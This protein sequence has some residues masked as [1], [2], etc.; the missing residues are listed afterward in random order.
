MNKRDAFPASNPLENTGTLLACSCSSVQMFC[1]D[2]R[3]SNRDRE[4]SGDDVGDKNKLRKICQSG[5]GKER[6][7]RV[8]GKGS[9]KDGRR[10]V[11]RRKKSKGA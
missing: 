6:R 7:K 2:N 10:G 4:L 9:H 11:S 3:K 5:R 8:Q 1:R